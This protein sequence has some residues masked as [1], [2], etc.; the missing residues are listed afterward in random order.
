MINWLKLD[1]EKRVDVIKQASILNGLPDYAI[2]KDWWVSLLLRCIFSLNFAEHLIFKGG[3]SLSKGW[4]LIDRFSEDIDL[5]IDPGFLG[6]EGDLTKQHVKKLRK[7]SFHFVRNEFKEE[8]DRELTH[9]GLSKDDYLLL[10]R[11]ITNTTTDPQVIELHYKSVLPDINYLPEKVLIEI[12]ARSLMEPGYQIGIKSIISQTFPETSLAEEPKKIY[13]V[14]PKR[15]FLEKVFLLHEEFS[16]PSNIIR[17]ERMSRHLYDLFK[18]MGSIYFEEALK[19]EN[20][21][22]SIVR[23]RSMLT[24]IPEVDYSKHAPKYISITPPRE[25]YKQ[26]QKDYEQ[27]C[28]SMIYESN[29]IKFTSLI[30]KIKQIESNINNLKFTL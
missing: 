29:P 10:T 14:H 26:W 17:T 3:T 30:E 6:F 16:K 25:V 2:E 12:G 4:N 15:T 7:A 27:M 13:T 8:L 1:K 19:D 5:G 11:K 9:Y 18:F 24:P 23:H 21:Y 22:R 20:L 28:E